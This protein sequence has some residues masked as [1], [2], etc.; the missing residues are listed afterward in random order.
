MEWNGDWLAVGVTEKDVVKDDNNNFTNSLLKK[1]DAVL[2]GLLAEAS[3][4]EGFSGKSGQAIVL[5]V[6]GLSFKRVGL[7]GLGQSAYSAAAF[8]G[9]GEA[10]AAAAQA[11]RAVSLAVALAFSADLSD[12][13]KPDIASSIAI[14]TCSINVKLLYFLTITIVII[15]TPYDQLF[16]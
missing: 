2:G 6:S 10:I 4:E 8:V 15:D 1:L 12:E 9:L 13:S 5:R 3:S 16:R 7:F 14:G 11:S